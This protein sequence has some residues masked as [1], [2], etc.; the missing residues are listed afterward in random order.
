MTQPVAPQGVGQTAVAVA[1]FR[2][3][4]SKRRNRLFHDPF[5]EHFVAAAPPLRRGPGGGGGGGRKKGSAWRML[6]QLLRPANY[7]HYRAMP[8]FIAVRTRFFD[9]F[10][11]TATSDCKQVVILAAGLDTR[12]YR[13]DLPSEVRVFEIDLPEVLAFKEEVVTRQN[14]VSSCSR[15]TVPVDLRDDW[16]PALIEAGFRTDQPTAWTAEGLLVYLSE[17]ETTKLIKGVSTLSAPG[18]RVALGHQDRSTVA[19]QKSNPLAGAAQT[20]YR[21]GL[22]Q[23]PAEWLASHGWRADARRAGQYAGDYGRKLTADVAAGWLVTAE[24]E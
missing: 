13:L 24:R 15:T 4:E 17:D 14:A 11:R 23:D 8:H 16:P 2:A 6:R 9:D 21:S 22:S 1:K 18:S 7:A 5:A 10:L 3:L 19:Q 20:L 12:A